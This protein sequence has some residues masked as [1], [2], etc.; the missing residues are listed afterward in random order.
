MS[1]PLIGCGSASLGDLLETLRA[2]VL[3]VEQTTVPSDIIR[4]LIE[5]GW[6]EKTT[7]L[8]ITKTGY[9]ALAADGDNAL[10][11]VLAW[12]ESEEAKEFF[13]Q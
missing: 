8:R 5:R 13:R 1:A 10:Q 12:L 2:I 4:A 6:V 3:G 11:D 7:E 9:Q